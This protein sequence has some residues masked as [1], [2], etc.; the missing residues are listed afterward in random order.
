MTEGGGNGGAVQ[1]RIR[2]RGR[3]IGRLADRSV[4]LQ[5]AASA[6]IVSVPAGRLACAPGPLNYCCTDVSLPGFI[7][8]YDTVPSIDLRAGGRYWGFG[9]TRRQHSARRERACTSWKGGLPVRRCRIYGRFAGHKVLHAPPLRSMPPF[10]C[11]GSPCF[12][13]GGVDILP[14]LAPYVPSKFQRF[15]FVAWRSGT[16]HRLTC[17]TVRHSTVRVLCRSKETRAHEGWGRGVGVAVLRRP[18]LGGARLR[19]PPSGF[20]WPLHCTGVGQRAVPLRHL[21]S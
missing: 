10:P 6:G 13:V 15:P 2:S 18:T 17:R 21:F 19:V 9:G 7:M 3:A 8:K 20:C 16:A 4:G 14:L 11:S 1:E 5:P 12:G